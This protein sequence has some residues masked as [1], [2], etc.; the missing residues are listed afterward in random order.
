MCT[1]TAMPAA[2]AGGGS[3]TFAAIDGNVNVSAECLPVATFT[4]SAM[5]G[6]VGVACLARW[7]SWPL[8]SPPAGGVRPR[9]AP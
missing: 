1:C 7:P 4:T 3:V 8:R 2:I 5:P 6:C 9:R